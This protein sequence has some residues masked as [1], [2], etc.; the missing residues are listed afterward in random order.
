MVHDVN[1]AGLWH[2]LGGRMLLY[3]DDMSYPD[4][5]DRWHGTSYIRRIQRVQGPDGPPVPR[6]WWVDAGPA[7]V[8]AEG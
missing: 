8:M 3:F 4:L 2:D 5:I 1:Q 6:G 7:V